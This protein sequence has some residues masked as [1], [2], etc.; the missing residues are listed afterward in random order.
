MVQLHKSFRVLIFLISLLIN[1]LIWYHIII[2]GLDD[3][4]YGKLGLFVFMWG[5]VYLILLINFYL[6]RRNYNANTR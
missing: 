4:F 2:F 3:N 5:F 6:D 1:V